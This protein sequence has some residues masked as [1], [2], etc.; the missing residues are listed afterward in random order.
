FGSG[1][2]SPSDNSQ[3]LLQMRSSGTSWVAVCTQIISAEAALVQHKYCS[4]TI[5]PS[6]LSGLGLAME[7]VSRQWSHSRGKDTAAA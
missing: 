3:L 7:V 5:H 4:V 2:S 1:S 6:V